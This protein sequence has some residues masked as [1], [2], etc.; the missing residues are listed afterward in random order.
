MV[1][2]HDILYIY[3]I[4]GGDADFYSHDG[5]AGMQ[6]DE[7]PLQEML[8]DFDQ[9][10]ANVPE[11][12]IVPFQDDFGMNDDNPIS[13]TQRHYSPSIASPIPQ[14]PQP[15][16]QPQVQ[17]AD[18]IQAPTPDSQSLANMLTAAASKGD[19][20][21]VERILNMGPQDLIHASDDI[22]LRISSARGHS[23]VVT[24][25]LRRGA[26]IGAL[27]HQALRLAAK[28]GHVD[29]VEKLLQVGGDLSACNHHALRSAVK[30]GHAA[31]VQMLLLVG[32][33]AGAANH[34]ALRLAVAAQRCDLVD[35]LVRFGADVHANADDLFRN[36]TPAMQACLQKHS[37]AMIQ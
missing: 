26:S 24:V 13:Q 15:E 11:D 16:M 32:A 4:L 14:I 37:S 8:Y 7:R 10:A 19:V 36:A 28:Q 3:E 17:T 12:W 1:S 31:M 30:E 25:L 9:A 22:A 18:H 27:D 2:I 33:D 29:V 20:H 23:A 35:L 34:D 5:A 21:N 6:T